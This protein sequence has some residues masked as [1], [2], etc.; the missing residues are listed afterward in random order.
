M[1]LYIPKLEDL[2]FKEEMLADP[3]TMSYNHA[4]GGTI[5][6]PRERWANWYKRWVTHHENK[7][8]YRYLMQ[9]DGT[10]VGEIAYRLDDERGMYMADVLVH[11]KYRGLG[12]GRTG[13]ELLC[14]ASKKNGIDVLYDDI[15]IDNP[16][17]SLFLRYGFTE[18]YRTDEIVML[19]KQL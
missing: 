8:F 3:E 5:P 18:E 13:L 1:D 7:R 4:Y 17:V 9:P 2:W 11:A 12:C 19:K 16:A 15:A 14:Q 6:F 10:F